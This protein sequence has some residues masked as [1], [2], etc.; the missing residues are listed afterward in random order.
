MY[1]THYLHSIRSLTI[2]DALV[3]CYDATTGAL[4]DLILYFL[5]QH[6]YLVLVASMGKEIP[7]REFIL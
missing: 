3:H 7:R 2:N 5:I 6:P 4:L 1:S